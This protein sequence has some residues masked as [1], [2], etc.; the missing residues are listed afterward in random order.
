MTIAFTEAYRQN[1]PYN[2]NVIAN[3]LILKNIL[4]FIHHSC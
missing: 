1:D 4:L 3:R 2:E